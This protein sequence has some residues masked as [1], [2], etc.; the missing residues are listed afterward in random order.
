MKN[1][2]KPT[3][4]ARAQAARDTLEKFLPLLVELE[5]T[6]NQPAGFLTA[7]ALRTAVRS[8][9][10]DGYSSRPTLDE[11]ARHHKKRASKR[12]IENLAGE[13]STELGCFV[14]DE[15]NHYT[16]TLREIEAKLKPILNRHREALAA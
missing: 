13:L 9:Y 1:T 3:I 11:P 2:R 4:E 10:C 12:D 5:E 15:N 14:A 7:M 8:P 16:P 6:F